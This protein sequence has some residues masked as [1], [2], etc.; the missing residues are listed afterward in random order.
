MHTTFPVER[1]LKAVSDWGM[2]GEVK[3]KPPTTTLLIDVTRTTKVSFLLLFP[4]VLHPVL[5]FLHPYKQ[6]AAPPRVKIVLQNLSPQPLLA[7]A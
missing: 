5:L 6:K 2:G 3:G 1:F 4:G 7:V